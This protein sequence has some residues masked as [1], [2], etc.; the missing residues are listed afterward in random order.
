MNPSSN[1]ITPYNFAIG[2]EMPYPLRISYLPTQSTHELLLSSLL[3]SPVG[4]CLVSRRWSWDRVSATRARPESKQRQAFLHAMS[5][6]SPPLN[7]ER[8]IGCLSEYG[9]D[10]WSVQALTSYRH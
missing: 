5:Y 10:Y 6:W 4:D 8:I 3:R 2:F 7:L 9:E 1:Q